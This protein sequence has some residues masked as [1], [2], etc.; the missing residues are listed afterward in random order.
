MRHVLRLTRPAEGFIEAFLIGNGRIGAAVRGRPG[1]EV[2]DLNADTLWSGGPLAP[3]VAPEAAAVVAEA[4]GMRSGSATSTAASGSH[5][6]SRRTA[7][8][9]PISRSA[10]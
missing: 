6:S 9:S 3:D 10:R 4:S 1:E 2:F 5:A 8:P 7:G